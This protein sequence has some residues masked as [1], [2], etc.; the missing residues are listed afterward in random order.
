MFP[1]KHES[2]CDK[3]KKRK[4]LEQL[5]LSQKWALDKFF[6]KNLGQSSHLKELSENENNDNEPN[7]VDVNDL[8][9]E[10]WNPSLDI[11]DPKI[12]DNLDNKTR[13]LLVKKGPIK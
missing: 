7:I 11:Y 6:V 5:T 3:R 10:H 12:W 4:R 13:D 8:N 9:E 1:K 2:G